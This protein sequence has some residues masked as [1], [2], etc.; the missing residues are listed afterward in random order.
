MA[1]ISTLARPYAE[2][3]FRVA[4]NDGALD[5][6][7]SFLGAASA[8]VADPVVRELVG[9][10]SL[11][12]AS[13]LSA[14]TSAFG[15]A[16]GEKETNFLTVLVEN[17]RLGAL[18][19]IATQFETLRAE[20]AGEVEAAIYT[21]FPLTQE[22]EQSLTAA[23]ERKFSKKVIAHIEEDPSLIGGVRVVVGDLNIDLSVRAQLQ[24]M[25]AALKS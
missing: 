19:E 22:Q 7:S 13:L 3:A 16:L 12:A 15:S 17:K 5:Q 2:A 20:S 11:P 18:P 9:R 25:T 8:V 4:S 23:L 10:P 21:A 24:H 14:I 1:D 6:W